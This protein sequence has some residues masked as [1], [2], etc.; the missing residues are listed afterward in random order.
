[1]PIN[2]VF[3]IQKDQLPTTKVIAR[4]SLDLQTTTKPI[5]YLIQI[6]QS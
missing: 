2:I 4:K 6:L 5:T 3:K 1:M